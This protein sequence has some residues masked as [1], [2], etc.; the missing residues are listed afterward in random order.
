MARATS[1]GYETVMK[2]IRN[3]YV[4]QPEQAIGIL[5]ENAKKGF[6]LAS[7]AAVKAIAKLHHPD[8]VP[9]LLELYEW[10][11]ADPGRRDKACDIR[12]A[13]AETLGDIGTAYAIDTLCRAVRTVQIGRLG[14][15]PEDLAIPL[16]AAAAIALAKVDGNCLY[17]LSLLLFDHEPDTPASPLTA[18]HVKA[19]VRQAAAQAI[20]ILGD[21]G[22]VPLLAVKLKFSGEEVPEVLAECLESLIAMRPPYLMEIVKPY[23]HGKNEYIAA[24]A[25]LS[26]AE[27]MGTEV[28]DILCETLEQVH[29]EAKEAVVIAISVIRGSGI[30][31]ILYDFLSHKDVF[32]RRGAVKG[33]KTYLDDDVKARLQEMSENDS[34]KVVRAEAAIQN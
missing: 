28:L 4:M 13:I 31:Q 6:A 25:A 19:P 26:L 5:A 1:G 18:P 15:T 16:R 20:G 30:R 22:G 34:D 14:P 10:C 9:T 33:I 32:V 7:A 21:M 24:I 23:L 27:N 8:I 2:S 17:E 12:L 3:T 11:E 29:G